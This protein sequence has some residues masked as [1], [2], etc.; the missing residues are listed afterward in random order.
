MGAKGG[1]GDNVSLPSINLGIKLPEVNLFGTN[2]KTIPDHFKLKLTVHRCKSLAKADMFGKSDPCVVV[3]YKGKEIARSPVVSK[4]LNPEWGKT[5]ERGLVGGHTFD[6]CVELPC[7]KDGKMTEKQKDEPVLVEVYDCDMK[8]LGD[9]LGC[10]SFRAGRIMGMKG[11]KDAE[12]ALQQKAGAK[13]KSKLVKGSVYL[14]VDTEFIAE[15][16]IEEDQMGTAMMKKGLGMLGR[17][18]TAEE[19]EELKRQETDFSVVELPHG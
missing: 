10:V 16:E 7:D 11:T 15:H 3:K 18:S 6:P 8:M 4:N 9:F 17:P 12:F 19:A 13:K 2:K 14:S 1:F 5:T